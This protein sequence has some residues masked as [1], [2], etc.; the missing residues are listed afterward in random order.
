MYN[1]RPIGYAKRMVKLETKLRNT[2]FGVLNISAPRKK[3]KHC[4]VQEVPYIIKNDDNIGISI[5]INKK[6]IFFITTFQA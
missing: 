5:L 6:L 1:A 3:D 2:N 4:K